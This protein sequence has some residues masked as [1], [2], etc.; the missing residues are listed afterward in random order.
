MAEKTVRGKT[1]TELTRCCRSKLLFSSEL[2]LSGRNLLL[3]SSNTG[4]EQPKARN[5]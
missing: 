5:S 3:G 2:F 4:L 1:R